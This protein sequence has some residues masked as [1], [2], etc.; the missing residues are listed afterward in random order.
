MSIIYL[1]QLAATIGV[2]FQ[3]ELSI[4][5]NSLSIYRYSREINLYIRDRLIEGHIS[6]PL[7]FLQ[8]CCRVSIVHLSFCATFSGSATAV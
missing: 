3:C 4:V 2:N 1:H 8:L 5:I 6:T 7:F